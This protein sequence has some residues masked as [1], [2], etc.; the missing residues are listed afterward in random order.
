MK[1]SNKHRRT[2]YELFFK[3][4][5][6]VLLSLLALIVLSPIFIIVWVINLF[7]LKGNPIFAQYRPGKNGKIFK[8]YKFRSMTNAVDKNGTP[9]PD[10]KRVTKFG[11][12]IRK[13]SLAEL[14]TMF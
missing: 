3:R 11:K 4:F 6:D 2:L 7:V 13:T 12:F 1:N 8:L 14:P 9:L 10:E 5:F